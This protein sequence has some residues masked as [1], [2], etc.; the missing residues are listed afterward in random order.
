MAFVDI[1]VL[2]L[3][4]VLSVSGFS[5]DELLMR[6]IWLEMGGS[7]ADVS[8]ISCSTLGIT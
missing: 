4:G 2:I 6:D 5:R 7:A 3:F 1:M 8:S